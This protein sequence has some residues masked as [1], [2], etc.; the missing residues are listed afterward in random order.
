MADIDTERLGEVMAAAAAGVQTAAIALYEEFGLHIARAV[1]RHLRALGV[2][3]IDADD[4]HGLTMDVCFLLTERAGSW[5]PARGALPWVWADR[6]VRQVASGFI[7][8]WS[9]SLDDRLVEVPAPA[10][11]DAAADDPDELELLHSLAG[12]RGDV[13]DY[14]AALGA[15][16]TSERN[17]RVLLAYRLQASLGDQSPAIPIGRR[18]GMTPAAVRQVVKRTTDRLPV[19]YRTAA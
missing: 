12:E 9:D 1:R 11:R 8:Q 2:T 15:A 17:Q 6:R 14:A 18:F 4:L 13:A 5:D 3:S 19:D 16:A 7:G 10:L